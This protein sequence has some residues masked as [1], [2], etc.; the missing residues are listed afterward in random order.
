MTEEYPMR[1]LTAPPLC[2]IS[3][4][5]VS[6]NQPQGNHMKTENMPREDLVAEINAWR[7]KFDTRLKKEVDK[8]VQEE[9]ILITDRE[10][11]LNKRESDLDSRIKKV[12]QVLPNLLLAKGYE[13]LSI[14]YKE[15]QKHKK[16][17]IPLVFIDSYGH[18]KRARVES[19]AQN[20]EAAL[21]E[22]NRE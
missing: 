20:L 18:D 19:A 9:K 11:A 21:K 1:P 15:L 2:Y 8:R 6:L 22:F 14:A 16:S 13:T 12:E 17:I 3:T 10:C 7:T 5:S 4:L